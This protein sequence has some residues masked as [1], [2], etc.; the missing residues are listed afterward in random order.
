MS[1]LRGITRQGSPGR[2]QHQEI[3]PSQGPDP[4]G[5]PGEEDQKE[6]DELEGRRDTAS[7]AWG[8]AHFE[9]G[10][11]E[12]RSRA[13]LGAAECHGENQEGGSVVGVAA[14]K[15]QAEGIALKQEA[16]FGSWVVDKDDPGNKVWVSGCD[17][18]QIERFKMQ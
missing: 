8:A 14:A 10:S 15:K 6:E 3:R 17:Y 1:R 12:P 13:P 9:P 5:D 11:R 4:I 16:H 2:Q 7:K 18:V